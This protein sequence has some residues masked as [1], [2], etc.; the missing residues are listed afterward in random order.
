MRDTF[1]G[2]GILKILYVTAND[3]ANNVALDGQKYIKTIINF[4]MK[5]IRDILRLVLET[6][7][8]SFS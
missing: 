1:A 8:A 5:C 2:L 4:N 7:F 3:V 6:S